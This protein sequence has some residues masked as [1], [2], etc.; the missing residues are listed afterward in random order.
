MVVLEGA[1]T[2]TGRVFRVRVVGIMEG[3][4]RLAR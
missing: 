3:K 4:L 2:H 1:D